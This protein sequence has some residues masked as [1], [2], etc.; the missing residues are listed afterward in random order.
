M[1][2]CLSAFWCVCV[3][4]GLFVCMLICLC[5]CWCVCVHVGVFVCVHRFVNLNIAN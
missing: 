4:V 5:A 2:V 3:H 1:F